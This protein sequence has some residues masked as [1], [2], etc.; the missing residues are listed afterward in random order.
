[1]ESGEAVYTRQ[2]AGSGL[3]VVAIRQDA[4]TASQRQLLSEFRL[5]QYALCSWYD[6]A[7]LAT[8]RFEC[9]PAFDELPD[10]TIHVLVGGPDD[11]LLAYF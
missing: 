9:D 3:Q 6:L 5:H 2:R 8:H 11:R 4:L 7:I 1:M 10:G